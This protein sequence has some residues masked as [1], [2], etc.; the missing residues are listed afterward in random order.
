MGCSGSSREDK[1]ESISLSMGPSNARH[2]QWTK[3]EVRYLDDSKRHADEVETFYTRVFKFDRDGFER[4]SNSI[5]STE[6]IDTGK[7]GLGGI[8]GPWICLELHYESGEVKKWGR[9]YPTSNDFSLLD[10]LLN[11]SG[12]FLRKESQYFQIS[13]AECG[14]APA[15]VYIKS[16]LEIKVPSDSI[17]F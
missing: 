10:S 1:L 3:T 11:F 13:T 5:L 6:L 8:H 4:V 16:P 7:E 12:D 15:P 14:R 9:S 17:D 2:I